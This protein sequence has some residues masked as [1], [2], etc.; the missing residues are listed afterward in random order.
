MRERFRL[1]D[2]GWDKVEEVLNV[3]V[4]H[5]RLNLGGKKS[6]LMQKNI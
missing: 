5:L 4:D 6:K 2:L 1:P 3:L